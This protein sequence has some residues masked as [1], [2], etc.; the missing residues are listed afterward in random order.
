MNEFF[1]AHPILDCLIL[2]AG[3]LWFL[4]KY[5]RTRDL[6]YI[7]PILVILSVQMARW[8]FFLDYKISFGAIF[9]IC[10]GF[11]LYE[12]VSKKRLPRRLYIICFSCLGAFLLVRFALGI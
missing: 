9:L 1:N 8:P 12:K 11:L 2:L 6:Q 10:I 5:I 4:Y 3:C 7:F